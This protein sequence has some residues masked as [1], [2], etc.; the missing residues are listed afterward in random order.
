MHKSSQLVRDTSK[1]IAYKTVEKHKNCLLIAK[2]MRSL[3]YKLLASDTY[4]PID[5]NEFTERLQTHAR[6]RF[7]DKVKGGLH[8]PFQLWSW[9]KGG[10][11]GISTHFLSKIPPKTSTLLSSRLWLHRTL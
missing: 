6:Y 7:M 3:N 4:A 2:D 8:A 11:S 9:K 10:S 1:V 5:V